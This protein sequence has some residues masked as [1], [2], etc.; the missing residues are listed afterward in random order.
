MVILRK[1][2]VENNK[3]VRKATNHDNTA[4]N[5]WK[6]WT[7]ISSDVHAKGSDVHATGS[8]VHATG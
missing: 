5:S 4:I 2:K 1:N 6:T 3:H 8:D 7:V